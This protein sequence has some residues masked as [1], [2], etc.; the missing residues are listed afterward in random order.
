MITQYELSDNEDE[1][2]LIFC[3]DWF[4]WFNYDFIELNLTIVILFHVC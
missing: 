4:I 2:K 3:I 1:N